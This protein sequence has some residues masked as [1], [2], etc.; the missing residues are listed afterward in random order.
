M[1]NNRPIVGRVIKNDVSAISLMTYNRTRFFLLS[2]GVIQYRGNWDFMKKLIFLEEEKCSR[3][4]MSMG[5]K[6]K[7]KIMISQR[8]DQTL[9]RVL[10]FCLRV[11]Q[12]VI[13][14]PAP[15]T[16]G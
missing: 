9:R 7:S 15:H 10:H 13:Y 4:Y 1:H 5:N 2:T 3:N 14:P 16:G 6:H 12:F 8:I 11:K